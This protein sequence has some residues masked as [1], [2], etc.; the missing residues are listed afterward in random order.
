M[1]GYYDTGNG[2]Q[3]QVV[4][5]F[6]CS[7]VVTPT[8]SY[9]PTMTP[10]TRTFTPT[11]TPTWTST[12]TWSPTPLTSLTYTAT[13]TYTQEGTPTFTYTSTTVGTI[14]NTPTPTPTWTSTY[15]WTPTPLASLTYTATPT[16]T[17]EGTPTSTY[18]PLATITLT[19][20]CCQEAWVTIGQSASQTINGTGGLAVGVSVVYVPDTTNNQIQKF[21]L[22]GQP[23]GVLGGFNGP[24][25]AALG[26]NGDIAVG[27]V[28]AGDVRIN[29]LTSNNLVQTL[30][31]GANPRYLWMDPNN[32]LYVSVSGLGTGSG[33]EV[34]VY[35][36]T[37][38]G[39]TAAT[40]ITNGMGSLP[41]GLVK[42]VNGAVTQLYVA[43]ATAS[44]VLVYTQGAGYSFGTPVTVTAGI[45]P[46]PGQM[47][48][49]PQGNIYISSNG[50]YGAYTKTLSPLYTCSSIL[51]IA[52]IGA[53]AAGAIYTT[54]FFDSGNGLVDELIKYYACSTAPTATVT[55]TITYTPTPTPT[56]AATKTFTTT[57]TKTGTATPTRT[58][59]LTMTPTKTATATITKTFTATLTPTKTPTVTKTFTKT[60]TPTP[61]KTRTPTAT[62][63]VTKT[64]T[65]TPTPT[66]TRTK[67]ITPTPTNTRT[68]TVTPTRTKTPTKTPT[69]T[70]TRTKTITPTPT[71]TISPTPTRTS[72]RTPTP[73]ALLVQVDSII[74]GGFDTETPTPTPSSTVT[75][76][77]TP[78]A[79]PTPTATPSDSL[80]QSVVAAP[81]I[82]QGDEPIRF[83][84]TLSQ[85]A[86]VHLSLY[87]VLG[88]QVYETQLQ[89]ETGLNTINWGLVNRA[90]QEVAIGL[91]LYVFQ[92]SGPSG[93]FTRTGK[94]IVLH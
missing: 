14:T 83:E 34:V 30:T 61:T 91:Y 22:S 80:L 2:L 31:P 43:D 44:E 19:P 60:I 84:L 52:G 64:F 27:E 25:S 41:T 85:H 21:T 46:G 59:T 26:S 49:G 94:I 42:V 72:T 18:T 73:T 51:S 36:W 32:D 13:P 6:N 53:D 16:F 77:N 54:G 76:V 56:S 11:P 74:V 35:Q 66:F 37:G 48:V 10:G 38:N 9:T 58:I 40:T 45:V 55:S 17:Q 71:R 47:A 23:A 29:N 67:T 62:P 69:P 92:V 88:E 33:G 87:T 12:Y 1:S 75:L 5:Y 20:G 86:L 4:Q 78:T 24:Y 93:I 65:K 82:S 50:E 3:D 39:Y 79:E 63:T 28:F 70:L 81:N 15:T 89:G 90:S 7:P 57:P 68:P 8:S